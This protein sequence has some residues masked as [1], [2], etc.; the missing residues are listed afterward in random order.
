[1]LTNFEKRH[2]TDAA[3]ELLSITSMLDPR[4]KNRKYNAQVPILDLVIAKTIQINRELVDDDQTQ[5]GSEDDIIECTEGQ[6]LSNLSIFS[7]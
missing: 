5:M 3:K 4:F 2:V 7:K 1:M 6:G